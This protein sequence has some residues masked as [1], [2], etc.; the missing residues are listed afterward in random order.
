MNRVTLLAD[1]DTRIAANVK[2]L[3]ELKTEEA[4]AKKASVDAMGE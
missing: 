4:A 2:Q 3:A 1:I